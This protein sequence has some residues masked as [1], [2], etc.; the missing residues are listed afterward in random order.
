MAL[1]EPNNV[2][3]VSFI[4]DPRGIRPHLVGPFGGAQA[5]I[6]TGKSTRFARF[7]AGDGRA[8]GSIVKAEDGVGVKGGQVIA[9]VI[10]A[11]NA[12]NTSPVQ[13]QP[14]VPLL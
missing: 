14:R 8:A 11:R 2:S 9:C 4:D 3:L 10:R 1:R 7:V 12:S 6:I 5:Q 13:S